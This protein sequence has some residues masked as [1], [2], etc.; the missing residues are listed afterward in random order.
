MGYHDSN[1]SL[2]L[3]NNDGLRM[4]SFDLYAGTAP[5]DM[6]RRCL[7]IVIKKIQDI[8]PK[9]YFVSQN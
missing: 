6:T 1:L 5:W 2:N 8:S 7:I 3:F 4:D 9:Q